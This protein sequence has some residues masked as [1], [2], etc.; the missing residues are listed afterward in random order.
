[1]Q[2]RRA[3]VLALVRQGCSKERVVERAVS[4]LRITPAQALRLHQEI[5]GQWSRDH[6]QA[7]KDARPEAI[8]RIRF[9]L[10]RLRA[11]EI[12]RGAKGKPKLVRAR[13]ARGRL[14]T[15]K[16][17]PV[18]EPLR[19]YDDAEITRKEKLLA[20]LEGSLAPVE[21]KQ[22]VDVTVR[23]AL[24]QVVGGLT[25]EEIQRLTDEQRELE[26]RANGVG[27]YAIPAKLPP[28]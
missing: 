27:E 25:Q 23:G 10:E 2:D 8:Q 15:R 21:H 6:A 16:G 26:L 3:H 18:M 17:K 24:V 5:V 19:R 11:G 22:D 1:M 7:V 28:G 13:N 14:I 9:D 4:E 12:V 20:E